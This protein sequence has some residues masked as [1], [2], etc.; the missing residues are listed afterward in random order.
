MG[1]E[2]QEIWI[3]SEAKGVIS[4]GEMEANDNSDVIVTFTDGS[5]AIST[6]FTYENIEFLRQNNKETGE[7]LSG[8]FFWASNMI[9]VDKINREG[10]EE[11]VNY[12]L[13]EDEFHLVFKKIVKD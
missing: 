7:C 13:L 1:N 11:I 9:L 12:L 8:K 10:I 6:F 3:E 5:R 2:I 4:G